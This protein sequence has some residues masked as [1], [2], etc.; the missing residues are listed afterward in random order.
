[1]GPTARMVPSSASASA[2][3]GIGGPSIGMT[4]RA[5][6]TRIGSR[7]GEPF[8]THV[9]AAGG[10]ARGAD[11]AFDVV[12]AELE[13]RPRLRHDVLFDHRRPEVVAAESQAHLPHLGAD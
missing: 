8:V 10:E 6:T 11:V 12:G 9:A 13:N 2:P 3:S 7:R 1:R 4:Q 5:L